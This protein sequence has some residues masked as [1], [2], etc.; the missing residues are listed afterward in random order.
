MQSNSCEFIYCWHWE[1]TTS[2]LVF[3][4]KVRTRRRFLK[5]DLAPEKRS[6]ET[7]FKCYRRTYNRNAGKG[8][9]E[10]FRSILNRTSTSS[11]VVGFFERHKISKNNNIN[12]FGGLRVVHS[13]NYFIGSY[14]DRHS[15]TTKS[16]G[17]PP[18]TRQK[19]QNFLCTQ[20]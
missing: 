1:R 3:H 17:P 7:N 9:G 4:R 11:I 12:V 14:R 2:C 13:S 19:K 6:F 20:T 8:G 15:S 10:T 18:Q 16:H 5:S